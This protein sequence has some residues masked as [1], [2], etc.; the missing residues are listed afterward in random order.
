MATLTS[1]RKALLLLPLLAVTV[2]CT[3]DVGVYKAYLGNPRENLQVAQVNGAGTVRTDWIN[4]YVDV[5]RF[6]AVDGVAIDNP[7]GFNSVQ[8]DPGFHDFKVYFSW[9]LGSQRGLAPALVN[10]AANRDTM[11]RTLR[12]NAL[13]GERYVVRAE[14]VFRANRQEITELLYVDFWV[15]DRQGN[16]VVSREAGR[17]LPPTAER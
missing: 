8:V 4:R 15:E 3:S 13:A 5:V 10:Y 7:E 2:A 1:L 6:L 9:D 11:S 12:F 17:Y 14:P 16:A